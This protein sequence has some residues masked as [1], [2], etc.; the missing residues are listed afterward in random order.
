[1]DGSSHSMETNQRPAASCDTVTVEGFAPSGSGRDHTM[2]SGSAIFARVS[3]PS[4]KRKPLVV[5]S[6]DFRD[7]FR[8]LKRGYLARLP[9]KLVNAVCRCRRPAGAAPRTPRTGTRVPRSSSTPSASPTSVVVDPLLP[10]PR[11]GPGGERQVVDLPHASERARQLRCLR[12]G[13]IEAVLE[14]P[15]HM[16]RRHAH[17]LA[18]LHLKAKPAGQ[19]TAIRPGVETPARCPAP[20]Q[21]VSSP[22]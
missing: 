11:L 1:M 5:Y 18:S 8:D 2:S 16:S 3:F 10:R 19:S 7:F 15:L 20:Q 13:R 6:A 9:K 22:P 14:R 12:I 21:S 17:K 4:R